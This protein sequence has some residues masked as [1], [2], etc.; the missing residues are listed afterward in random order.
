ML[1]SPNC[2]LLRRYEIGSEIRFKT[3]MLTSSLCDY[4]DSYILVK[5][6]ITITGAGDGEAARKADGRNKGVIFKYFASFISSI[7]EINNTQV[8]DAKKS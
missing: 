1:I 5:V 4:S 2:I 8:D 7:S 3:A 6:T